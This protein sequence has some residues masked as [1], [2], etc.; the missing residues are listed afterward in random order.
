MDFRKRFSQAAGLEY[1]MNHC[2]CVAHFG[3]HFLHNEPGHAFR[4]LDEREAAWIRIR[5]IAWAVDME[6]DCWFVGW[7][8]LSPFE[9]G[10]K[11]EPPVEIRL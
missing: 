11:E 5:K 8:S 9:H 10:T 4:P 2:A 7:S 3:D 6:C 1:Y